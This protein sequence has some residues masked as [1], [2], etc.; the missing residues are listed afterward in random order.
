MQ[1][2]YITNDIPYGCCHC[3]CGEKTPIAAHTNKR[4]GNIKGHPANFVQGHSRRA[5]RFNS[6]R[7]AFFAYVTP[8][9]KDKCWEWQGPTDSSKGYGRI[10]T[11]GVIY[12]A[13]RLSY[14]LHHRP[15]ADNEYACHT[16]DNPICVNPNHLFAGTTQANHSDMVAKG[17]HIHGLAHPR[18]K[19]TEHQVREIR[20]M[21]H[22]KQ[23][24]QYELAS[25]FKVSRTLIGRIVRREVWTHVT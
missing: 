9:A 10:T 23:R 6:A 22:Q 11:G 3:G 24:N 12:S 17:R 18:A 15:L 21:Y 20:E 7:D 8:G 13:H 4:R 1:P 19:L 14:E 25:L 5:R 2:Q 16:C